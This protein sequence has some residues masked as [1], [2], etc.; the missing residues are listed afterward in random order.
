MGNVTRGDP[1]GGDTVKEFLDAQLRV[2][3]AYQDLT[4]A[5]LARMPKDIS[6]E[7]KCQWLRDNGLPEFIKYLKRH[8]GQ[9]RLE[10]PQA[11]SAE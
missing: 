6:Y 11:A 2:M 10:A 8:G 9:A 5:R 1:H 4:V 3:Q 7:A